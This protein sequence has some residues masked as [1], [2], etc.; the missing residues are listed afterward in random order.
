MEA[1]KEEPL[2]EFVPDFESAP[3]T[4]TVL[5]STTDEE[6]NVTIISTTSEGFWKTEVKDKDG[7]PKPFFG[8][9]RIFT[10]EQGSN[11][12]TTIVDDL[13]EGVL[14]QN[15][16]I[17]S[18]GSIKVETINDEPVSTTETKTDFEKSK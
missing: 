9:E 8:T 4:E 5:G 11:K 10:Q 12:S 13:A 18:D 15:E 3:V 14:V 1:R 16:E 6:G 17:L 7:N 2:S